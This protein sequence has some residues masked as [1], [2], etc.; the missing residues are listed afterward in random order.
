MMMMT[1]ART[2]RT[3]IRVPD[4]TSS[5]VWRMKNGFFGMLMHG[6]ENCQELDWQGGSGYR[7]MIGMRCL[8]GIRLSIHFTLQG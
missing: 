5:F 8:K 3:T 1:S 6:M 4:L 2:T 7:G